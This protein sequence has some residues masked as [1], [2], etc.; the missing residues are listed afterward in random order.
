MT[1]NYLPIRVLI[2]DLTES[3]LNKE[4][5]DALIG[6]VGSNPYTVAAAAARAIAAKYAGSV[7]KR[8]GDVSINASDKYTHYIALADK[9][10]REASMRGLG[11]LSVYAGGIS[12]SDKTTRED[13]SDRT[14]PY[15]TRATHD[16]PGRE[17]D[18]LNGYE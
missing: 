11:A 1:V 18:G 4:A 5:L 15:F 3:E 14:D 10:D 2:G 12:H 17:D 16:D 8:A 6:L 9:L 7:T 13:D